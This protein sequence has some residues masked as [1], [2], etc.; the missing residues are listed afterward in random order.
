VQEV[1]DRFDK[2]SETSVDLAEKLKLIKNT[3]AAFLKLS[4]PLGALLLAS[5]DIVGKVNIVISFKIRST[6]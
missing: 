5:L 4:I 6:L 2:I 1:I 3:S